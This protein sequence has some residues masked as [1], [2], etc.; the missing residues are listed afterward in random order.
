MPPD[1]PHVAGAACSRYT[2]DEQ[3]FDLV[4]GVVPDPIVELL[5]AEA[6][7]LSAAEPDATQGIRDLL[8]KSELVRLLLGEPWLQALLSDQF[9]CV[10]GIL[11]DKIPGANWLVAWH[12]DLTICVERRLDL[13]GYGPWSVKH[14][15]PHVQPPSM[16]LEQMVTLRLHLDDT[17]AANGALRV[18]AGSHL[19]G[20]LDSAAIEA[21]RSSQSEVCCEAA[22]G[23]VML[24]KP[25]L[26]HAS[27]KA[28]SPAH[29]RIV[30]LEFAPKA[31]LAEG[32]NWYETGR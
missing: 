22:P 18:I 21:M 14:G 26:L 15:V 32:L 20:K 13:A 7:R 28:E 9:C 17:R 1:E 3:G 11:F 10:R 25:L 16:L 29:R 2:L 31:A 8:R 23:D 4:R 12:Q 27:S 30:H 6:V 19:N 24:M 5:K